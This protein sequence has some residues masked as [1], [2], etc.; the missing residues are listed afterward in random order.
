MRDRPLRRCKAFTIPSR[1]LVKIFN[2][3]VRIAGKELPADAVVRS[4]FPDQWRDA[5]IVIVESDSFPEVAECA[6]V[7]DEPGALSLSRLPDLDRDSE[8]ILCGVA[9]ILDLSEAKGK[10][11]AHGKAIAA[12]YRRIAPQLHK[13]IPSALAP[14]VHGYES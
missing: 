11:S 5:I 13:L 4:A 14:S 2:G 10:L 8:A 12:A 6:S 7:P 3:R 9:Q 1:D